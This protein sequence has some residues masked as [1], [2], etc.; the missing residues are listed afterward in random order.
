M[1]VRRR[2]FIG[3]LKYVDA[4]GDQRVAM[5]GVVVPEVKIEILFL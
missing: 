4:S 2:V 3:R 1:R 5:K